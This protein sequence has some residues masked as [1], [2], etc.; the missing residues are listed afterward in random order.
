MVKKY[1]FSKKVLRKEGYFKKQREEKTKTHD[2]D[3]SRTL[4]YKRS[5]KQRVF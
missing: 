5:L 4:T 1:L 3:S 2:V